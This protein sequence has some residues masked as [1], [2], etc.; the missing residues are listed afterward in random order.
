MDNYDF[1]M[2]EGNHSTEIGQQPQQPQLDDP[3]IDLI[4][5]EIEE[6]NQIHETNDIKKQIDEEVKKQIETTVKDNDIVD[7]SFIEQYFGIYVTP[8]LVFSIFVLLNFK[9]VSNYLGNFIPFM[10]N[11]NNEPTIFNVII[12]GLFASG[13]FYIVRYSYDNLIK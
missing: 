3:N 13:M 12:R 6:I 8:L 5:Q 1:D 9:T 7:S 2:G 4:K 10:K 11:E